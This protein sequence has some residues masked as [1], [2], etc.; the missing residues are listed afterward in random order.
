MITLEEYTEK[1]KKYEHREF[2][3]AQWKSKYARFVKSSGKVTA[4]RTRNSTTQQHKV[5]KVDTKWI[6]TRDQVDLTHCRLIQV[7]TEYKDSEGILELRQHAGPLINCIDPAHVMSRGAAPH[8]KYDVDNIVPL[9]RFSHSCM[10]QSRDP[11]TGKQITSKVV[12]D[13][14]KI[15]IGVEQYDELEARK[16]NRRDYGEEKGS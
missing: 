11:V 16:F 13:W 8:M 6:E 10:D 15:L 7:L 2:N 12:A 3:T 4:R 1:Q 14:W 5:L 9:N